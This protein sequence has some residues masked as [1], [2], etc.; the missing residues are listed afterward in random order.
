MAKATKS[1]DALIA[2]VSHAV[3]EDLSSGL[4]AAVKKLSAAVT[5]LEE[6]LE[7]AAG[8]R[9]RA[10]R[11]AKRGR[12]AAG[13]GRKKATPR[14]RGAKRAP[15]G[16]LQSAIKEA[17]GKAGKPQKLT[18]IRDAVLKH[19]TFKGRDP[20]TLYTMIV[21]A[22]K[23]MPEVART[24]TGHYALTGKSGKTAKPGRPGRKKKK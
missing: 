17:V 7:G 16:A 12:K 6:K 13:R 4:R 22:I 18:Q 19:A 15:R 14:A 9:K 5:E 20:K 10:G 24:S 23:K 8:S 11:P 2:E 1:L 3:R 21:L